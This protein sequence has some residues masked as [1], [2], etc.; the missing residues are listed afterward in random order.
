MVCERC[1][2]LAVAYQGLSY[3][4]EQAVAIV[5]CERCVLLA[6]VCSGLNCALVQWQVL[7][8]AGCRLLWPRP[9]YRSFCSVKS[10]CLLT[11]G[12]CFT[13]CSF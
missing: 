3:A 7:C 13:N 6:G 11:T 8:P 9:G 5:I 10:T 1:V 12:S 2:L 4:L